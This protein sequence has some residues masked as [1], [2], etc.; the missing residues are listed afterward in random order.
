[1]VGTTTTAAAAASHPL[2]DA[3]DDDHLD[4]H[5]AG[6][7]HGHDPD[8]DDALGGTGSGL[9]PRKRQRVRL[10]CLECRRRKLSCSREL[11]CDRCIKSGTPDKCS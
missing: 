11:P 10:S 6:A 3:P 1:M 7:D 4:D 9:P 5:H 2:A 8:D